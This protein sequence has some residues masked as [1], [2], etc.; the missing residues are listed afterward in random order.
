MDHSLEQHYLNFAFA[1]E[2]QWLRHFLFSKRLTKKK[3]YRKPRLSAG[4]VNFG[5]DVKA[6]KK[7]C[8]LSTDHWRKDKRKESHWHR[9]SFNVKWKWPVSDDQ[10]KLHHDNTCRPTPSFVVTSYRTWIRVVTLLQSSYSLNLSLSDLDFFLKLKTPLIGTHF[11]VPSF[12]LSMTKPLKY[13]S[14][15]DQSMKILFIALHW[16]K[17]R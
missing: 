2:N 5:K 15:S 14:G 9:P 16:H 7:V 1:E 6:S 13:K 10:W 4:T 8:R 3:L 11:D 17:G 12:Q